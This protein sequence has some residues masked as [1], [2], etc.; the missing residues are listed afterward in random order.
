[1]PLIP[2]PDCGTEV[3]DRAP[4]CPKCGRPITPPIAAPPQVVVTQAPPAKKKTTPAAW[5]CLA[6]ILLGIFGAI[7]SGGEKGPGASSS[8]PSAPAAPDP[9]EVALTN[10][11]LDFTWKLGGFDNVILAT[12]TVKNENDFDVKDLQI[13]C[14]AFGKSGTRIDRNTRTIYDVVKAK[15]TKRL[16]EANLGLV[17]SQAEKLACD[18]VDFKRKE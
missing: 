12:F 5:G 17:N 13:R 18:I 3:S 2:C 11:K 16:P 10:L 6:L 7:L 14:E 4:A 15:G 9:R 1:M 8:S